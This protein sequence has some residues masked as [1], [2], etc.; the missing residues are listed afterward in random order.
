MTRVYVPGTNVK[1]DPARR[2]AQPDRRF[3]ACGAC[4]M[5]AHAFLE[6]YPDQGFEPFWIRPAAGFTGN[7][8]FIARAGVAFDYHGAGVAQHARLHPR[9]GRTRA[10]VPVMALPPHRA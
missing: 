7:H 9:S 5:L 4:H 8:S 3:F 6:M 1:R 10:S 2:W